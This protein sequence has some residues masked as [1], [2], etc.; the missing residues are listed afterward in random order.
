MGS[1]VS[2]IAKCN[3]LVPGLIV[4]CGATATGKSR[5]AIALAKRLNSVILSADSRQVYREFNIGTAK[6]TIAE[7]KEVP[8]Y[9]IDICDPTETLTLADYQAQAQEL[10]ESSQEAEV[11]RQ[12]PEVR[13]DEGGKGSDKDIQNSILCNSSTPPL[14][15]PL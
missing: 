3:T 10:I 5:L 4:V 12:Q 13:S 2:N 14:P 11:R 9:L 7:Q 6:P 15:S 8:H 1:I